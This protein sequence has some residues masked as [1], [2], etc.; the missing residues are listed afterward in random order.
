[1]CLFNVA[2]FMDPNKTLDARE[3]AYRSGLLNPEKAVDP[4]LVFDASTSDYIHFLCRQ[5]YNTTTLRLV[6]GDSSVCNNTIPG[7]VWNLNYPSF[8]LAI[9]DGEKIRGTFTRTVTNVGKPKS[10]YYA[11]IYKPDSLINVTVE[12]LIL[13]FSTV[14]EKKTL[15]LMDHT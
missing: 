10:T 2:N 8:S 6:T 3:F 11:R 15:M 5:G 13:S 14:G 1:M 7:R 9:E 12:P 4:G